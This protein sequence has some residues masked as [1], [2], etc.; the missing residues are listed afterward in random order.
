M[1][2]SPDVLVQYRRPSGS[3]VRKI[4]RRFG[5]AYQS[6]DTILL[7]DEKNYSADI[8]DGAMLLRACSHMRVTQEWLVFK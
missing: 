2:L 6:Y 3:V 1:I 7:R 8:P 5:R 4:R